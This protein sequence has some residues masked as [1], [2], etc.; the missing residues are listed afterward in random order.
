MWGQK[1]AA[2]ADHLVAL[3]VYLGTT[4]KWWSRSPPLLAKDLSLSE[5][6]VRYVLENFP[7]FFRKSQRPKSDTLEY[8]YS[9]QARYAQT[10]A[11]KTREPDSNSFDYDNENIPEPVSV[12]IVEMLL[13]YVSDQVVNERDSIKNWITLGASVI[14]A[15]A[16]ITAAWLSID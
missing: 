16:A 2:N 7:N 3:I 6:Q 14:A 15:V 1:Y 8:T 4:P 10:R 12:E 13:S 5:A 9:L 11:D